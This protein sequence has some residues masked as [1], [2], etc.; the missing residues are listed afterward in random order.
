MPL[1]M[2][3][4]LPPTLVLKLGSLKTVEA[5]QFSSLDKALLEPRCAEKRRRQF[6]SG[7]A[8]V[9]EAI[10][11]LAFPKDSPLPRAPYGGVEWPPGVVGSIAHSGD[12]AVALIGRSSQ[13][14]SVG[15]DIEGV[16]RIRRPQIAERICT[17][18]EQEL[19]VKLAPEERSRILIAIFSAKESLFKLL[20]PITGV[21]FGFQDAQTSSIADSKCLDLT[22]QRTLSEEFSIG[23]TVSVQLGFF[24]GF[25]ITGCWLEQLG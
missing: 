5:H 14:R 17:V 10:G 6:L 1:E 23:F 24:D 2:N 12:C 4:F 19:L 9:R 15:V 16:A 3:L 22:L 8:L 11:E 20:N 25:V 18:P 13:Y 21:F 7:R